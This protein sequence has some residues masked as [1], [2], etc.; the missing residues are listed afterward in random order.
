MA[1]EGARVTGTSG[2]V[3]KHASSGGR[4]LAWIG[5][6]FGVLAIG[7]ALADGLDRAAITS[8]L[9][10]LLAMVGVWC[11][12]LR[13]AVILDGATLRLRNPLSDVRIPLA[14]VDAVVV[15]QMLVVHTRG[16]GPSFRSTALTRSR[17]EMMKYDAGKREHDP[18]ESYADLVE[19]RIHVSAD[20]ARDLG[21]EA[22]SP[23]RTPAWPEVAAIMVLSLA[24]LA[25]L[26]TG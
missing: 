9:V 13:P 2:K 24:V 4:I 3:E 26:L 5:F 12:M 22:G 6:G 20:N 15:R 11:V 25:I 7:L 16:G 18:A 17:R 10:V 19:E 14:A 21:L 8:V 23:T 1:G